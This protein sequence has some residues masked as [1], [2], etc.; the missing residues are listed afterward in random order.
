VVL[1][2][3]GGYMFEYLFSPRGQIDR[4][5][6]LRAAAAISIACL[7]ILFVLSE[8]GLSTLA[9]KLGHPATPMTPVGDTVLQVAAL[10]IV[11]LLPAPI[12]FKRLRDMRL[13][14]LLTFSTIALGESV[15][16]GM[17]PYTAGAI[18]G[19]FAALAVLTAILVLLSLAPGNDTAT[20]V[21][22]RVAEAWRLDRLADDWMAH[23]G[24]EDRRNDATFTTDDRLPGDA[25]LEYVPADAPRR[26]YPDYTK[27]EGFGRRLGDKR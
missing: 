25:A 20:T 3:T 6:F 12:I 15:I 4:H 14:P 26:S 2:R 13:P 11:V 24:E 21:T 9:A 10:A 18:H 23:V 8:G 17:T 27:G 19:P 7:M 16:S 5:A 1:V 22:D